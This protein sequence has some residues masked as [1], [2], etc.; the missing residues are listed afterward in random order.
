MYLKEHNI[1]NTVEPLSIPNNNGTE[2]MNVERKVKRKLC[3]AFEM[4]VSHNMYARV[5]YIHC[6]RR[7]EKE[8]SHTLRGHLWFERVFSLLC[9]VIKHLS[10]VERLQ[11]L[12]TKHVTIISQTCNQDWIYTTLDWNVSAILQFFPRQRLKSGQ[13][14][15]GGLCQSTDYD[16]TVHRPCLPCL[17]FLPRY[18]VF[19]TY[20]IS[21]LFQ[22]AG[23]D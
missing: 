15:S 19:E 6:D 13:S 20:M 5:R 8:R 21:M 3:A 2:E 12:P 14:T 23:G 17:A 16:C 22:K 9:K 18:Q 1:N 11:K 4:S 7:R 10:H